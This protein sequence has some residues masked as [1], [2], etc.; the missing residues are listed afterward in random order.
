MEIVSKEIA[1]KAF[2]THQY[3]ELD[4][5]GNVSYNHT[6]TWGGVDYKPVNLTIS[7][8]STRVTYREFIDGDLVPNPI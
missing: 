4:L 6:F 3:Y 8:R 7:E 2:R 1:R 5:N